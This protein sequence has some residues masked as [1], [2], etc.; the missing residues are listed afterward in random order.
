[1]PQVSEIFLRLVQ[2]ESLFEKLNYETLDGFLKI[3]SRYMP[4]VV[5]SAPRRT[6]GVPPLSGTVRDLLALTLEL[7][8]EDVDKLWVITGDLLVKQYETVEKIGKPTALDDKL[9][10]SGPQFG[11]GTQFTL[12]QLHER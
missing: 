12:S 3:M 8:Y 5:T 4:K 11:L 6:R 7:S 9:K 2:H 10:T 1:M